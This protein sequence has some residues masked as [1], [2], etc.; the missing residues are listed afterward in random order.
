[1]KKEKLKIV[2]DFDEFIKAIE[3]S[4]LS[5]GEKVEF[6]EAAHGKL[7]PN[8]VVFKVTMANNSLENNILEYVPN[9]V[10][11]IMTPKVMGYFPKWIEKH[12]FDNED[13]DAFLSWLQANE[14]DDKDNTTIQ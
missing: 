4:D 8:G 9:R 10:G 2:Q 6:F 13:G 5:I 12:C 7:N 14:K 1:M 11:L 3:W